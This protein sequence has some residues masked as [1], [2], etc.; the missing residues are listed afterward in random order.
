[1]QDQSVTVLKNTTINSNQGN[2]G[3]SFA[4]EQANDFIVDNSANKRDKVPKAVQINL[5]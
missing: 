3:K 4:N 5:K 1:M 2:L